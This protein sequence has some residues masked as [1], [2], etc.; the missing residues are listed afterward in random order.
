MPTDTQRNMTQ[1]KTKERTY[2]EPRDSVLSLTPR[3]VLPPP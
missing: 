1:L 2:S 3:A